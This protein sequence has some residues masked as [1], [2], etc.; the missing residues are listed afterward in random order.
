MAQLSLSLFLMTIISQFQPFLLSCPMPSSHLDKVPSAVSLVENSCDRSTNLLKVT[1]DRPEDKDKQKI[2]VC[3]KFL[4]GP[5]A[6]ISSRMTEWI[7]LLHAIGADQI[8]LYDLGI[9]PNVS[10]VSRFIFFSFP[11]LINSN[12]KNY[13]PNCASISRYW[14]IMSERA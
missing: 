7:E 12:T 4:H 5:E 10:K 8:F 2:G 6:D 1:Y 11:I 13:F 14:S 9:H 3:Q